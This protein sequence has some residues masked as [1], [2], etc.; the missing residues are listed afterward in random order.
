MR[1]IDR[2]LGLIF[3]GFVLLFSVALARAAWLQG[4]KGGELRADARTQQV[5]TVAVPGERGRVIDRNGKVLA[6]SEDAAT[7]V[8]TPYQVED[9]EG[10]ARRL[11]GILPVSRSEVAD[12]LDDPESGFAYIARKVSLDEADRV[13]K[14]DIH[15]ISSIPDTR[16]LY[17]AMGHRI[18]FV[19]SQGHAMG[20]FID[21][22]RKLIYGGADSRAFNARAVGW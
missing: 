18:T 17:E 21:H 7:I 9:P 13:E 2:R 19:G 4:V 22:E 3:C 6:V 5:T 8:A 14:L 16:R 11:A 1:L 20:I 15:G 10:A 12:A